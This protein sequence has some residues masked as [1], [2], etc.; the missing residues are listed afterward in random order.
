MVPPRKQCYWVWWKSLNLKQ[1][2]M[3][4]W[5]LHSEKNIL[6]SILHSPLTFQLVW[7]VL[8]KASEFYQRL[9]NI[10]LYSVVLFL[11]VE[12]DQLTFLVFLC[13]M[14]Y[15]FPLVF[16]PDTPMQMLWLLLLAQDICF[17]VGPSLFFIP[18]FNL[19]VPLLT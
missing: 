19:Y 7:T 17:S 4:L 11:P 8:F 9:L 5:A 12:K 2:W 16:S 10:L 3:V 6:F 13:L 1:F 18:S 14:L 15:C